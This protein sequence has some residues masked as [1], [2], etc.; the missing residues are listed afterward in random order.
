MD[1]ILTPWLYRRWAFEFPAELYPAVIERLRG[2]PARVTA[3]FESTPTEL[4]AA[5]PE[6]GWSIIR[7]AAHLDDLDTLLH[8]RLDAYERGEH[9]LPP[10]DMS[11]AHATEADHE[12]RDPRQVLASLR[13]TRSQPIDRLEAYPR[14]FFSRS[15]W[16]ERLGIQKR[17]V[18]C[19]VFFADHDDHHL[20]LSRHVLRTLTH[21]TDA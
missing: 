18:D 2:T 16:H 12:S 14:D 3:M 8:Q 4:I 20:A 10:A 21:K 9:V 15:A 19:C 1:Q 6:H 7:H 5:R 11:N 17:V 13:E